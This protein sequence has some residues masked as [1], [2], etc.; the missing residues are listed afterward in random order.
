MLMF[1]KLRILVRRIA[2]AGGAVSLAATGAMSLTACGQLGGL[3][4]PTEPAAANRATLLQTL[5][6]GSAPAPAALPSPAPQASSP[7]ASAVPNQ[8]SIAPLQ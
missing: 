5:R 8:S 1:L 6:A 2:L 7:A 3:Y 4:L